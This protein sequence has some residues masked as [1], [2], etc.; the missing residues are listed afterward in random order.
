MSIPPPSHQPSRTDDPA[1]RSQIAA[2]L[3]TVEQL[4]EVLTDP[5][6]LGAARWAEAL[7]TLR[8]LSEP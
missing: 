4:G 2:A 5:G 6:S 1:I 3:Q 7:G 8:S